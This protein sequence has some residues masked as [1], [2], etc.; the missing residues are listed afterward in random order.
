MVDSL[1]PRRYFSTL[2]SLLLRRR[3]N[4]L[5]FNRKSNRKLNP[6]HKQILM[7]CGCR[8]LQG[9]RATSI[10]VQPMVVPFP[11]PPIQSS[12]DASRVP[13]PQ[14]QGL[15][16]VG[17]IQ[18]IDQRNVYDMD[19]EARIRQGRGRFSIIM[20]YP[21]GRNTEP[22]T[23]EWRPEPRANRRR[24]PP[25]AHPGERAGAPRAWPVF[26]I[27]AED[28]LCSHHL[29]TSWEVEDM[30]NR[31]QP[32]ACTFCRSRAYA[33]Y[34]RCRTCGIVACSMHN[35]VRFGLTWAQAVRVRN[36]LRNRVWIEPAGT[37]RGENRRDE[38]RRGWFRQ[39]FGRR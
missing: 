24:P 25:L 31:V 39:A 30:N 35:S 20:F 14:V 5:R 23:R 27:H 9:A 2:L 33:V 29:P 13:Q 34:F 8:F 1:F 28:P 19:R 38:N 15:Q 6:F 22:E 26:A 12:I 21:D 36:G 18:F 37:R 7:V 17:E 11:P 4:R 16:P 32:P 10:W 3:L